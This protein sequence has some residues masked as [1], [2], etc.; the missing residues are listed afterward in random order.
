MC[1]QKEERSG[2]EKGK[3]EGEARVAAEEKHGWTV[4]SVGVAV[5]SDELKH[6]RWGG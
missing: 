5:V 6:C 2:K 4:N 3:E 1:E